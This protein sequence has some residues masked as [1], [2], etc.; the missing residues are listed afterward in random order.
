MLTWQ[1]RSRSESQKS[2]AKMD[3]TS[4]TCLS[5]SITDRSEQSNRHRTAKPTCSMANTSKDSVGEDL[6]SLETSE[7]TSLQYNSHRQEQ[8]LLGLILQPANE[9]ILDDYLRLWKA[10]MES[11]SHMQDPAC[12]QHKVF[13]AWL[14]DTADPPPKVDHEMALL[15]MERYLVEGLTERYA[16]FSV[17]QPATDGEWARYSACP[18]GHDKSGL[19]AK[20]W[21]YDDLAWISGRRTWFFV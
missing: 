12:S 5:T 8:D 9:R 20:P 7:D 16:L 10:Y 15:P 11:K 19:W 13:C 17:S 4:S 2:V 6:K 21:S 1:T 18:G 14:Q 3:E